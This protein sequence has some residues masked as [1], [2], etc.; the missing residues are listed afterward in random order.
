MNLG[1]GDR[2]TLW[3]ALEDRRKT[4]EANLTDDASKQIAA[5]TS[6]AVGLILGR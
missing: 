4:I 3:P 6:Y 5:A 2:A 1:D